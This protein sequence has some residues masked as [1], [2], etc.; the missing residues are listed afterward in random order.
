M[1]QIQ[2]VYLKTTCELLDCCSGCKQLLLLDLWVVL[3]N[4]NNVCMYLLQKV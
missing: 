3:L 1:S 4:K 2:I